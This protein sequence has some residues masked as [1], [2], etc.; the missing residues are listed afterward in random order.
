M[1][2]L[3]ESSMKESFFGTLSIFT[4]V[5]VPNGREKRVT[6]ASIPC[7]YSERKDKFLEFKMA[8]PNIAEGM[9]LCSK[10]TLSEWVNTY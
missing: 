6:L 1:Q 5:T 9:H 10:F 7:E 3:G 8:N 4:F 2:P